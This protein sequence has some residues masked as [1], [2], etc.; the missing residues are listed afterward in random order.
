MA[1]TLTTSG[2]AILAA[3]AHANSTII[4]SGSSLLIWSDQAE[5]RI[6]AESRRNWVS[7]YSALPDGIKNVLSSACSRL[8]GSSIVAYDTTGYLPREAD[9]IMNYNDEIYTKELN[10]LKDFKSNDIR[11]V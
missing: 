11:D 3:G 9:M 6:V 5:G 2:S 10:I 1:W 8:I 4:A 7:Q